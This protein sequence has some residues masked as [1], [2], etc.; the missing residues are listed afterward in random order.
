MS[1]LDEVRMFLDGSLLA[2]RA[3][4][5][6]A[7]PAGYV[8]S[9]VLVPILQLLFFVELG[10]FITGHVNALY[11]AVGN[12]LQVTAI[13]GIYGVVMTL[14]NERFFGTLP[15]LLGSPAHRVATFLGRSLVHVLDGVS[16]A[17]IGFAVAALLFGLQLGRAD[18]P[19]FALCVLLVSASTSGLGLMLGSVSLITRDVLTVGNTVYFLLMVLC[20][21]NFPVERLPGV[22]Q[23]VSAALPM[24]RGIAAARM[25]IAGATLRQVAPLLL[26]EAA[27]GL[28]YAVVGYAIF[29]WLEARARAGGRLEAI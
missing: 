10:T 25:A 13:N 6:W 29:R 9:K 4:F 16:S 17:A 7:N 15:L 3:L 21:V 1:L 8:A 24:T 2:Y 11:F 5:N 18:L 14:G 26:G 22:L 19:L 27:I 23:A 12:A 20:G 28:A